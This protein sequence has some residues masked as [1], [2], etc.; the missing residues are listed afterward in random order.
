MDIHQAAEQRRADIEEIVEEMKKEI[1]RYEEFAKSTRESLK[2][3]REKITSVRNEVMTSVEELIRLLHDHE[4][5]MITSLDKIERK[6]Q[7]EHEA[8]LQQFQGP[9]NQ[10]QNHIERFNGILQRKK[11]LEILQA[12][13]DLIER[14]RGPLNAEK[15]N[16]R[17]PS[18]ARYK[19]NKENMEKARSALLALGKVTVITTDPLT[20]NGIH[21]FELGSEVTFKTM[22]NDADGN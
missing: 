13:H 4:E 6:E 11:S 1:A 14:C 8:K 15:P 19:A 16:I 21:Q 12:H 22:I 10:I 2:K 3:T 5:A 7:R 17:K 20:S 9:I 18:H